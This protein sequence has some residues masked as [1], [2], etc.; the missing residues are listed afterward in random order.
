MFLTT[1]QNAILLVDALNWEVT[2][3]DLVNKVVSDPSN[4]KCI[5][6]QCTNCPGT[7]ALHKFLEEEL[8]DID[9]DFQFHYSQQQTT[10]RASLVIV[11]STCEEYKDALISARNVIT[12][13]SFLAKC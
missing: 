10:D 13:H 12:K 3:K 6:H 7:N 11:T 1:H 5:M 8:S 9:P 4:C 2:Y